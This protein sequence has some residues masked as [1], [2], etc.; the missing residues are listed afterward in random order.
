MKKLKKSLERISKIKIFVNKC[1]RKGIHY[2]P[3]KGD[4]KMFE[5]NNQKITLNMI[6][7]GKINICILSAF[8]NTTQVIK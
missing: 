3:G 2:L 6:Y 7:A 5:K 1:N 4:W 8:Q